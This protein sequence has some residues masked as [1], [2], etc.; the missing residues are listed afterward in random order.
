MKTPPTGMLEGRH[1]GTLF[2]CLDLCVIPFRTTTQGNIQVL[3]GGFN[4]EG[5]APESV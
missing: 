1:L 5:Q 3:G 4:W 2:H